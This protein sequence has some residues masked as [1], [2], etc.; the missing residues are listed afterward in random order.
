[1]ND[2]VLLCLIFFISVRII[3]LGVS[4]DYFHDTKDKKFIYLTIGWILWIIAALFPI[5]SSIVQENSIKEFY[6]VLN[7]LFG[8]IGVI[9]Y[10][11]GFYEYFTTIQIKKVVLIV[12]LSIL[13][14][15]SLYLLINF[16][17]AIQV[18]AASLNILIFATYIFPRLLIKDFKNYLGKSN[19][20]YNITFVSLVMFIPIYI[21]VSL[22]GYNYGLYDAENTLLI[23]LYYIP[24]IGSSVLFIVLLV[25]LEYT[26]STSQ[27]DDLKDRFSHNL[28][29]IMQVI[30][31]AS[32]LIDLSA[33]LKEQEKK[34][35]NLVQAK[36]KESAKLIKEIREL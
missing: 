10:T 35:L 17:I 34:N 20:W 27:K 13:L 12:V 19:L 18:S 3:G 7:A 11:W 2:L 36:C 8:L 31:S 32:D 30:N 5:F 23:I 4:I 21:I 9:F 33:N 24:T 26:I 29:N 28:G 22:S 25:H 16:R 1:M 14:S 15:F 6:L